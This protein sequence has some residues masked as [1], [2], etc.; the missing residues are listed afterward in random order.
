MHKWLKLNS[1]NMKAFCFHM[2]KYHKNT[3]YVVSDKMSD[4]NGLFIAKELNFRDKLVMHRNYRRGNTS[5]TAERDTKYFPRI[6]KTANFEACLYN[7]ELIDYY[8]LLLE[9]I[10]IVGYKLSFQISIHAI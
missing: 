4:V 1:L 6:V 10:L 9:M 8:K 2:N 7:T 3:R 5:R